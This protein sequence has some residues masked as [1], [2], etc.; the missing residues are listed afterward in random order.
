MKKIL[1]EKINANDD[2]VYIKKIYFDNY[3]F[4]KKGDILFDIESSKAAFE[5]INETEGYFISFLLVDDKA[6]FDQPIGFIFKDLVEAKN[7]QKNLI[8]ESIEKKI[9]AKALKLAKKNYILEE[10]LIKNNIYSLSDLENFIK[11]KK[12]KEINFE[13]VDKLKLIEIKNL[14]YSYVQYLPCY[15]SMLIENFDIN[16]ISNNYLLY[17]NNLMPYLIFKISKIIKNYKKLNAYF[18]DDHIFYYDDIN[19]G[20]TIDGDYGLKVPVIKN[21]NIKSYKE[22]KIEFINLMK[23]YITNKLNNHDITQPSFVISDLSHNQ[24]ITFHLPFIYKKN[25]AILGTAYHS[26]LKQIN[27]TLVYDHQVSSGLESSNFLNEI[28]I[29]IKNDLKK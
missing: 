10:D 2:F 7:Y 26:K 16:I 21:A 1:V 19:I 4:V 22:I 15:C 17:F 9:S 23:K 28:Y 5:V 12:S 18:Y 25:S 14:R 24:N 29:N 8:S 27:T 11:N 13:K 3:E 6:N 20:F